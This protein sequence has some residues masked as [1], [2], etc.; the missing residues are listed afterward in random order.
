MYDHPMWKIPTPH[1]EMIFHGRTI[2]IDWAYVDPTTKRIEDE[3]TRNTHFE[4]WVEAGPP[5]DEEAYAKEMGTEAQAPPGGW[6]WMN[7]W[8]STHDYDLDCGADDLETALLILADLVDVF[9]DPTGQ[10][11]KDRP[12]RCEGT[13]KD[14]DQDKYISGCTD[15]G[16]GFCVRCGFRVDKKKETE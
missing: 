10:S 7:K 1:G 14:E 13:F 3:D 12:V 4:V 5:F 15:A 9:Y 11:R 2:D 6:N 16:D 8:G